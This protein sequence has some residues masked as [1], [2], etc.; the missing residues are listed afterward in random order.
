MKK[1][2]GNP[3]KLVPLTTQKA[4]EIGAK[5]GKRSGEAKRE[6]KLMSQIY[7][8]FLAEK[9]KVGTDYE[10][11]AD[12][13]SRIVK[14]ILNEGGSPAV[15]LM[16]EIREATEGTKTKLTGEDGGPVEI[17][18]IKRVIVGA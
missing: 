7:G 16:K 13:V 6:K 12:I 11:G 9:F 8:E 4:R 5:G 17:S 14:T 10:T 2:R 15:S 18:L 3:E 1:V